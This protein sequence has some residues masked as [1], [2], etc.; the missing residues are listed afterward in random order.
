M[1]TEVLQRA[2]IIQ[3][4]SPVICFCCA[5]NDLFENCGCNV[6]AFA[7]FLHLLVCVYV[8]VISVY[9]IVC[10]WL[11]AEDLRMSSVKLA[12]VQGFDVAAVVNLIVHS[13]SK[14]AVQVSG[15]CT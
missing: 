12:T 15:T 9:V 6:L 13:S 8:C 3:K 14:E 2:A 11:Q 5:V 1:A 10:L 7:A 4:V